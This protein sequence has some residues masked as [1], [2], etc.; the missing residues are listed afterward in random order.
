MVA[1]FMKG[2][3][4]EA[5][6]VRSIRTFADGVE[7]WWNKRHD[8]ILTKT[9]DMGLFTTAVSICSMAGAAGNMAVAVSA[10]LIGGKPVA[11]ALKGLIAKRLKAD[12]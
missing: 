4:K 2:T 10:V 7:L 1:A 3:E 8:A 12:E 11:Q 6:V 5:K 9:F